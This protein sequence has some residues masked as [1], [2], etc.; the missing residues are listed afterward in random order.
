M[1]WIIGHGFSVAIEKTTPKSQRVN[2]WLPYTSDEPTMLE[3][4]KYKG[5]TGRHSNTY[6]YPG[7]NRGWPVL[8]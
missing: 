8:R 1:G 5:E 7:L 3:I 2:I 4:K 6:R